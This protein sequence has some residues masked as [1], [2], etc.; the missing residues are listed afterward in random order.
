MFSTEH[1]KQGN[2]PMW[3]RKEHLF[4]ISSVAVLMFQ[5]YLFNSAI[6][7][8][9]KENKELI[10]QNEKLQNQIKLG[11]KKHLEVIKEKDLEKNALIA[12]YEYT[13]NKENKDPVEEVKIN[14]DFKN[15]YTEGYHK[16]I[17]DSV[18]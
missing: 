3:I 18:D 14:K 8:T 15:G 16:G 17:E 7:E 4:T 2:T 10:S 13:I 6:K 11:Y 5:Y 12:S 1:Q 9:T